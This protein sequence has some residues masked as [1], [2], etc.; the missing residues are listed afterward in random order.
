MTITTQVKALLYLIEDPDHQVY[1][2]VKQEILTFGSKIIPILQHVLDRTK[3]CLMQERIEDILQEIHF[4]KLQ[5]NFERWSK[6]DR[7]DLSKG[8]LLLC[9]YQYPD[10]D[11]EWLKGQLISI[12]HEI[13]YAIEREDNPQKIMKIFNRIFFD[14]YGFKVL[15]TEGLIYQ[16]YYP[17]NVMTARKGEVISLSALYMMLATSLK[18]PICMMRL[19]ENKSVLAYLG[20][21][22]SPNPY[23]PTTNVAF[24]MDMTMSGQMISQPEVLCRFFNNVETS[25]TEA[26]LT[27]LEPNDVLGMIIESLLQFH[28]NQKI[29]NADQKIEELEVLL[30]IVLRG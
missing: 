18:L 13:N 21:T 20:N 30:D 26:Y 2:H 1:Q 3:N 14:N 11:L 24:Y 22:T 15:N 5:K 23:N 16:Y 28:R 7:H 8:I 6:N 9:T 25:N 27:P 19:P 4:Q 17:H 29:V 10:I 12:S